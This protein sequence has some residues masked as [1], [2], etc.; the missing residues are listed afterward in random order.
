MIHTLPGIPLFVMTGRVKGRERVL[1]KAE[2]EAAKAC[3]VLATVAKEGLDIPA[4][5]RIYLPF[6]ASNPAKVQQWIGRGTRIFEGKSD[7][8]VFDFFDIL[9]DIFRKQFRKR[10]LQV[11]RQVGSGGGS[12]R[13][14]HIVGTRLPIVHVAMLVLTVD[15]RR[16]PWTF[17]L[18]SILMITRCCR[19]ACSGSWTTHGR[20]I[21]A[22]PSA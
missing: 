10:T 3:I 19:S 4:V 5:D 9:I 13:L 21:C 1:M 11:L 8:V 22:R 2:I 15:L 20:R 18:T 17:I 14:I 6:P 7:I 12:W 16:K